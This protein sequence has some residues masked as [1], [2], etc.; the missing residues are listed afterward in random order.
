MPQRFFPFLF[1]FLLLPTS[2]NGSS[3]IVGNWQFK[4]DQ[5]EIVAEFLQDGTFRQVNITPN[6]KQTFTG[7][8]QL[9][10]QALSILPL[11]APQPQQI[12]CRFQD[13][14]TVL[15]TY[16]SGET[17]EWKRLKYGGTPDKRSKLTEPKTDAGKGG[18]SG[19]ASSSPAGKRPTL[20]MQRTWEPNEKAF[21][22]LLP[23]GWNFKGGIFNVNPL[24]Q[25]G[26]GNS[27]APKCDLTVQKDD[28]G[29]VMIR[30]APSWN[31]ADLTYSPTGFN[32]FKP[33]QYYQGMLVKTPASGAASEQVR[34]AGHAGGV[35]RGRT[36]VP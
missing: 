29:M 13:A 18:L 35:H 8:Y 19:D 24:T 5:M 15:A 2:S 7:R 3:S 36:A 21:T 22:F 4:N 34:R 1:F 30:F 20:L 33:G 31:Y 32:F 28:Q 25:N 14:D 27:I 11:G 16:P 10:G 12:V 9:I 6:G 23:R 26:P 17:L